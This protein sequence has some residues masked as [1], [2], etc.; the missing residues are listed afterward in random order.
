MAFRVS[1]FFVYCYAAVLYRI[2]T[3]DNKYL[4]TDS[5]CTSLNFDHIYIFITSSLDIAN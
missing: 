2:L 5:N 3:T 4:W 1:N